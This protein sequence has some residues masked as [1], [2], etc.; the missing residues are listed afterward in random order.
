[1][2]YLGVS[3]VRCGSIGAEED[4]EGLGLQQGD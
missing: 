3:F 1:M 2:R 4:Y